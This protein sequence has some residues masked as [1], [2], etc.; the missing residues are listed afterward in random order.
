MT[1]VF[2]SKQWRWAMAYDVFQISKKQMQKK[3]CIL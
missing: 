2:I 1:I 3:Q